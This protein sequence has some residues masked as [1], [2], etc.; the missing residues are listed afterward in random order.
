MCIRDSFSG[1]DRREKQQFPPFRSGGRIRRRD[2][3]WLT[4]PVELGNA[5]HR[6]NHHRLSP[7]HVYG[8]L[9]QSTIRLHQC[10]PPGRSSG[11]SLHR[12]QCICTGSDHRDQ[13]DP[14]SY[15]HLDVYKRQALSAGDDFKGV[16]TEKVF[17]VRQTPFVDAVRESYTDPRYSGIILKR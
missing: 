16:D 11:C 8:I 5:L 10:L 3:L 15:T 17:G 1:D 9:A 13:P 2:Q 14:V 6:V 12:S 4:D 7:W